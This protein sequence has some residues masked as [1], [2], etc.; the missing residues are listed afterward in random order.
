MVPHCLHGNQPSRRRSD[1]LPFPLP[2]QWDPLPQHPSRV[3]GVPLEPPSVTM[4][5]VA[6]LLF[7]KQPIRPHQTL[8]VPSFRHVVCL[9]VM[10][11]SQVKAGHFTIVQNNVYF[12]LLSL[13]IIILH[14]AHNKPEQVLVFKYL[15]LLVSRQLLGGVSSV[16]GRSLRDSNPVL[17]LAM[18]GRS[19]VC[20]LGNSRGYNTS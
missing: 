4:T 14:I 16:A 5:T 1:C 8:C 3:S 10:F 11:C 9:C 17:S 18:R 20:R 6:M 12:R 19:A 15:Y 7:V 13:I 2:Q